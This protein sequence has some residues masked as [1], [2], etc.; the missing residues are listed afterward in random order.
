MFIATFCTWSF[1]FANLV[2]FTA[3]KTAKKEHLNMLEGGIIAKL[4]DEK[5]NTFAKV[6]LLLN[7]KNFD[8]FCNK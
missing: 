6:W 4:L 8:L 7:D 2:P 5:W 3:I 1:L